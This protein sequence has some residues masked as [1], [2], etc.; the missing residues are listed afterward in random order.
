MQPER[1]T[2]KPRFGPFSTPG[3]WTP[4]SSSRSDSP[5]PCN[6]ERQLPSGGLTEDGFLEMDERIRSLQS[7]RGVSSTR[8]P[9][10]PNDAISA[11][12]GGGVSRADVDRLRAL[13]YAALAYAATENSGLPNCCQS[14]PKQPELTNKAQS[15]PSLPP[16]PPPH[17]L[18][19][20]SVRTYDRRA[21]RRRQ[22]ERE[23]AEQTEHLWKSDPPATSRAD[24]N[25]KWSTTPLAPL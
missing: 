20:S 15:A 17:R 1:S 13:A 6:R 16:P 14:Y 19:P 21:R 9:P 5:Y 12:V 4:E 8:D 25:M 11:P 22:E 18:E 3:G 10:L 2:T 23:T 7:L 24:E